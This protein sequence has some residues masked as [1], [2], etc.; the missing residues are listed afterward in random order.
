[1]F[2]GISQCTST[3]VWFN[4][5]TVNHKL[6]WLEKLMYKHLSIS[7][8]IKNICCCMLL[9]GTHT[10]TQSNTQMS[11]DAHMHTYS[12]VKCVQRD[13]LL[14][15]QFTDVWTTIRTRMCLSVKSDLVLTLS[16]DGFTHTNTHTQYCAACKLK[17]LEPHP[18]ATWGD[19]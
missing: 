3:L 10:R 18:L 17:C 19:L 16:T 7:V 2:H 13:C 15:V 5:I 1:M 11:A 6:K 4:Y 9:A 12:H 8:W 14:R